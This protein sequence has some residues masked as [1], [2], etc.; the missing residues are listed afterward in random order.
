MAKKNGNQKLDAN[1]TILGIVAIF[2][3]CLVTIVAMV[4]VSSAKEFDARITTEGVRVS[5]KR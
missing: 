4:D 3:A 1:Q 5:V 2:A